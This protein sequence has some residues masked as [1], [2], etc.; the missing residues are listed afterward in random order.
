MAYTG[1]NGENWFAAQDEQTKQ[2]L[3]DFI[4][5]GESLTLRFRE[6]KDGFNPED[7][8][9]LIELHQY[10]EDNNRFLSVIFCA[11]IKDTDPNVHYERIIQVINAGVNVMAVEFG[12][13]VYSGQ[14]ADFNFE[15]YR[16]WF[17]PLKTLIEGMYPFMP[18]LVF[19]APRA[20]DSGVMGGRNDHKTFNDAAIAYINARENVY[21]TI[22]IYMNGNECP[23]LGTPLEKVVYDPSV[24]LPTV[25]SFYNELLAAA[26]LNRK[27]LWDNTLN[28][29]QDKMPTKRIY[30]TEWGFDNYG[31]IKN[32][33]ATGD[34]AWNTW[35]DYGSDTRI[36]VMLQ[37]NGVSLA[38]PGMISPVH[39]SNDTP[40]PDGKN[41]RRIDYWIFALYRLYL[42]YDVPFYS[43]NITTVGTYAEKLSIA[44]PM[45]IGNIELPGE[46]SITVTPAYITGSKIYSS[47][48]ATEWM[49]KNS[50]PTYEVFNIWNELD[51]LSNFNIG[52]AITTVDILTPINQSPV[53][54]IT[55]NAVK[56]EVGTDIV[57]D[58]SS[59]YDPDGEV[60][61]N[62]WFIQNAATNEEV[63]NIYNYTSITFSSNTPGKFFVYLE[64]WDDKILKSAITSME[65]EFTAKTTVKPWW[66]KFPKI[67]AFLSSMGVDTSKCK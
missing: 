29:M 27:L 59:S 12:N 61:S 55:S 2:W 28:Y 43:G 10:F 30:I 20:K 39:K 25:N 62:H 26:V 65:I 67:V 44:E 52:F 3:L 63:K 51:M 60:V 11:N 42:Q 7:I 24:D 14:Q 1:F 16:T 40:N 45:T 13:E 56:V 22:H 46:V 4:P 8:D 5:V 21:P 35:L 34:F 66:C 9:K 50:I 23:V 64:V 17:E 31:D 18:M 37:H 53:A 38:G 15:T 49:A 47:A 57:L 19:L 6:D 32:T 33:M 36:E 48:G 41:K 58:S 54:V